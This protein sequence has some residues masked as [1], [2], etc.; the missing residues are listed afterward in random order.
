MK[1]LNNSMVLYFAD[2]WPVYDVSKSQSKKMHSKRN[3]EH[4]I[5]M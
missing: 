1:D 5:L 2:G 4:W 3:I